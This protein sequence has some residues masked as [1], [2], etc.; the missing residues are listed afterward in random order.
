MQTSSDPTKTIECQRCGTS[1]D[2]LP[3]MWGNRETFIP[4]WCEACADILVAEEEAR[5]RRVEQEARRKAFLR[6]VPPL[7]RETEIARLPPVLAQLATDWNYNPIGIGMVGTSGTGKTR[8][9]VL[10]AARMC[11]EGRSVFY[12]TA[13]DY[14][15]AAAGQWADDARDRNASTDTLRQARKAQVLVLDDIGKNKMTDRAEATLYELLEAR[16]SH[17]L[18]TIWTSNARAKELHAMFSSDRADA[19]LRRLGSDFNRV[20]KL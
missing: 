15:A 12:V 6:N 4:K 2:Y 16:T 19:M 11:D 8:T 18:P 13:T 5:A 14:A 10:I 17:M 20:V 1:F 9:A 3:V 7:Y